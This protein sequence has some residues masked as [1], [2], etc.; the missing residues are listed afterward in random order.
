MSTVLTNRPATSGYLPKN[1][2][3]LSKPCFQSPFIISTR[4]KTKVKIFL[5]KSFESGPNENSKRMPS[6]IKLI[7][8]GI[9]RGLIGIGMIKGGAGGIIGIVIVYIKSTG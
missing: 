3:K 9:D 5:T 1:P 8:I 7:T 2:I 6:I 4:P